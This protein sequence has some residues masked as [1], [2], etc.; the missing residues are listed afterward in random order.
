MAIPTLILEADQYSDKN[1][2]KLTYLYFY[3]KSLL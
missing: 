3:I 1:Q 2:Q